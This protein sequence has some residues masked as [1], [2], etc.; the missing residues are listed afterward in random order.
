M[1]PFMCGSRGRCLVINSSYHASILFIINPLSYNTTYSSWLATS[2]SCTPFIVL[3]WSYH[4]RFSYPFA[5]VPLWEWTYISAWHTSK[6]Y[7]SYCFRKRNTCSKGGLPPFLS[8]HSMN[9]W[10]FLLLE[11]TSVFWWTLSL[12]TWFARIWCNKH[13]WW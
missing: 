6:H 8:P 9:E 2:Y 10:I 3:V 7:C 13:W 11:T 5:S 4:R 1:S 12:L